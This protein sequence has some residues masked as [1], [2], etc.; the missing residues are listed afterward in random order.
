MSASRAD[1]QKQIAQ[2]IVNNRALDAADLERALALQKT[3]RDDL[4]SILN[5]LG[6]LAPEAWASAA[7]EILDVPYLTA[8][9][10]K[11]APSPDTRVSEEFLRENNIVLLPGDHGTMRMAMADPTNNFAIQ[12]V[13]QA[14]NARITPC[15]ATPRDIEET[16]HRIF[17]AAQEESLADESET[18]DVTVIHDDDIERLKGLASEAPVIRFVNM[19]IKQASEKGA[20]DI[21]LEPFERR[22]DVRFRID[23]VLLPGDNP[24]Q[25][26]GPAIISRLKILAN[27]DIAERRLAQDGRIRFRAEGQEVDLRVATIPSLHGESVVI[28]LLEQSDTPPSLI[29]LGM[30]TV[31]RDSFERNLKHKH[32][33]ILVTGPTGSG[34]T[35]TLYAA[36]NHL[37]D[38]ER[39]II[40]IEDPIEFQI[41]QVVQTQVKPAIGLDFARI[42]KS[43]VRQDPDIIM[44][45]E[46]RDPETA[47]TAVR[48]ALTGH[49]VLS[50]LHT[51]DAISAVTRLIDMGVE[52]YLLTSTM[53]L[54]IAQRLI[55]TLCEH[56]KQPGTVD[57]ALRAVFDR[58][59]LG[60][61]ADRATIYKPQGC[62]HCL[63]RG[64]R[65]RTAVYEF[66]ELDEGARR[67]IMQKADAAA[68]YKHARSNGFISMYEHGLSK[69]A[70]GMT[71]FEEVERL[72]QEAI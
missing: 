18:A 70:N 65:G 63:D 31:L 45:G 52:D 11:E 30:D 37:N 8:A 17:G 7:S 19:M 53:R 22:F 57:P 42:L 46:M 13:S 29:D 15:A 38:R 49:L 72:V 50:T 6:L 28:R 10:L 33:L 61:W 16:Q 58:R 3:Y 14:L 21:H 26:M 71:T 2:R 55:R 5:K 41:D 69:I 51:N 36:L 27:L 56:C 48:S 24:P 9:E 23:G 54:C 34:K 20:S 12:A 43:I 67:L 47:S 66:F 39:K 64:Y 4:W 25:S 68:L 1:L 62:S 32:G 40:T 35:T 60:P 44:L 59:G